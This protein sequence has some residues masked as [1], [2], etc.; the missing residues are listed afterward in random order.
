MLHQVPSRILEISQDTLRQV[1]EDIKGSRRPDVQLDE[2]RDV[3]VGFCAV[4]KGDQ[5]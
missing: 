2:S 3:A 1:A 4:R 5:L